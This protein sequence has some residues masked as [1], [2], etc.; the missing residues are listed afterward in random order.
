MPN[1]TSSDDMD[2]KDTK[3]DNIVAWP[4][5]LFETY[6]WSGG[7]NESKFATS[8]A[9]GDT[10]MELTWSDRDA[11]KLRDELIKRFPLWKDNN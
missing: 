5:T 11:K 2:E 10:Q 8:V 6:N 4:V 1:K 7:D 3:D 9:I